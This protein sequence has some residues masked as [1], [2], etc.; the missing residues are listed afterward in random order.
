MPSNARKDDKG[1]VLHKGEYQRVDGR[2]SYSYVDPFG[3]RKVVYA[4]D[5][6]SLRKKEDGLKRDQMDGLDTYAAGNAV[7]N[8]LF[9]RYIN[10]KNDL[11]PTTMSNYKYMYDHFVRDGFGKKK[12]REIKYSDVLFFYNYLID[13]RGLKVATLDNVHTTL[14]PAFDMAV[15]DNLIRLNPTDG[16]MAAIKKTPGRV[17]GVRHALTKEQ[18]KHFL[19]YV[20]ECPLLNKW[21]P[22]FTILLGTG[23]RIGEAIGLRWEDVDFDR[24]M[25]SIN[26]NLV[27]YTH[28][29]ERERLSKK[30][31]SLPKT[32]AGVRVIP[33][34][35]Q[36]FDAFMYLYE[37]QRRKRIRCE[38]IDGMTNFVFRHDDG[39]VILPGTI[40][41]A[42]KKA[43]KYHNE[44]E[45]EKAK[46]E[47]REPVLLP[48]FS[49]HHLRH[50]FCTR[51]CEN[52]TN[53]KVIQTIMG[54]ADIETTMD[55]Y[56]EVTDD[57]KTEAMEH[58]AM[59]V[60]IF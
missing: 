3:K 10:S 30:Q 17:K 42:I 21:L 1:R 28:D 27:Y 36:V 29:Y 11:R 60:D 22:L 26:H 35:P 44:E 25:I 12:I 9:D 48:D 24:H 31:I 40:N 49:C 39:R 50:T 41:D 47:G 37:Y 7:L 38:K 57:K 4:K 54:H 45:V 56:A 6:V 8:D 19:E 55:I 16:V 23:M 2:Y 43:I 53:V 33:M 20:E 15:R 52:E 18:Q 58:L 46:A 5:I 14:H 34:M 32:A 13:E 59:A 51:F